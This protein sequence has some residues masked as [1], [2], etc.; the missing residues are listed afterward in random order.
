M[1]LLL[2]LET[3]VMMHFTHHLQML[4]KVTTLKYTQLTQTELKGNGY[5]VV[6][7]LNQL[8]MNYLS[9]LIE[10]LPSTR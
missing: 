8:L 7:P 4:I 3:F 10:T 5:L 9:K 6:I 2:V 1:V